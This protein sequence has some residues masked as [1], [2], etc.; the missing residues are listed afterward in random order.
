[1]ARPPG[2][3]ACSSGE[4]RWACVFP[5][6][7][8]RPVLVFAIVVAFTLLTLSFP[9]PPAWAVVWNSGAF[10]CDDNGSLDGG[11]LKLG[12]T[13]NPV[14]SYPDDN[15]AGAGWTWCY[16]YKTPNIG[17]VFWY[18]F[19][20]AGQ[21]CVN[22]IH[23]WGTWQPDLWYTASYRVCAWVAV[24]HAG[25]T[26]ARYII[27]HA[28]GDYQVNVDQY[29]WSGWKDLGVYPFNAGTAGYVYLGDITGEPDWTREIGY[30]GMQWVLDGG[31]CGS[32]PVQPDADRD[33]VPDAYDNC[34][35]IPNPDQ[36]D[37]D[38]DGVGDVCDPCANDPNNDAD[39]DGICVG[40]GYLP[41][42]TS[43]HD[44]CPI[45]YNP[46][47]LDT[48]G[49]GQGDACDPDDDNDGCADVEEGAMG[50]DSLAWYDVFD[51]P[52]PTHADMRP[53]GPRNQVVDMA[54][55]LGVLF[56]AFAE[57]T[58]T[59]GDNPNANGVDYDCDKGIDT[60]GDTVADIPANG[61]PD[62][63][64]YD[65]SPSAEPN[66]PWEAGPPNGV[67]DVGDTLAALAQVF[68]V[69][70]SGPP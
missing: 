25:T 48:D 27:H 9:A 43:D 44:N 54:D 16:S 37:T 8:L 47:Q 31:P 18:T 49:D 38:G 30:D 59:C 64:D 6:A 60:N 15:R 57:P 62:G 12:G 65:R 66:P 61:I 69:D 13:A 50:Y 45:L 20:C 22:G 23:N 52:V 41:P 1:M 46:D 17:G 2:E 68:V 70:C 3:T 42:K 29:N 4:R 7:R 36:S 40:S 26:Q 32:G 11:C 53:N 67:I 35:Y 21:S 63:R 34:V 19:N 33:R 55:V 39:N 5:N 24:D 14:C 51:V 28:A 56:Y 58:G 10:T